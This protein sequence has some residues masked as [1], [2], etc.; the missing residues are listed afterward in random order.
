MGNTASLKRAKSK[1]EKRRKTAA[2]LE[3][4][5]LRDV[6]SKQNVVLLS[7]DATVEEALQV[8]KLTPPGRLAL[9][10]GAAAR[11]AAAQPRAHAP[12]MP[13]ARARRTWRPTRPRARPPTGPRRNRSRGRCP[14]MLAQHRVLSAPVKLSGVAPEAADGTGATIFGFV[15]VRDIVSS[16]F[17]SGGCPCYS[18]LSTCGCR[19]TWHGSNG[20]G[21][22][23]RARPFQ[24]LVT[25]AQ[26]RGRPLR[27]R[28][29]DLPSSPSP[30]PSLPPQSCRAS[31]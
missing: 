7:D 10:N 30:P 8:R 25:A 14:Q 15:D 3:D 9:S 1:P 31:T 22:C 6:C 5:V 24:Q 18:Y 27:G 4:T 29:D 26:A 11:R 12:P 20:G 16:F 28:R 23:P 17:K 19:P 2:L 13:R 21:R